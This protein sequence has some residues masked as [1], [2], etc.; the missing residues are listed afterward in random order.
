MTMTDQLEAIDDATA[1]RHKIDD[2]LARFSKAHDEMNAEEAKRRERRDRLASRPAALLEQTRTALQR[3]VSSEPPVP[4]VSAADP[5][6]KASQ[7]R[8]QEKKERH[9]HRSI[10]IA[11]IT[12]A[13]VAALVFLGTGGVWG[14]QT[15]LDSQFIQVAALDENSSDINNAAAQGGDE[16]FLMVGSDSRADA[17][18]EE[19]IGS[20]GSVPGARS[21]TVMIA[22]IPA[23]RHNVVMTSFPRDLEIARPDCQSWD[24]N[25]KQYTDKTSPGAKYAKLNTAFAAGGPQCVT[26]VIQKITGLKIN[27]FVAIDFDGFK[28]MVDAVQG[29]TVHTD[30]PIIDSVLGSVVPQA[31]DVVLTGDQALNFVRARHVKGD[32]TSDY[33]RIKRQQE[34][35]GA[36]LKKVMSKEVM[37][38]VSKI[39][40]F[41][42]G[43]AKA[44]SGDNIDVNQLLTLAESMRGL[45]AGKISFLTVP[46][47]GTANTRG[48]EVLVTSKADNLFQ[49]LINNGPLPDPNAPAAPNDPTSQ[50]TSKT[51][52]N[53]S[54][55]SGSSKSSSAKKSSSSS[56]S[57]P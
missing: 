56:N 51:T 13:V 42:T 46:T 1:Y 21:D 33:G 28:A 14:Y 29:V 20:A 17:S 43:F 39:S 11:R 30:T 18:D 53:T 26:K 44:T 57:A 23:D 54:T 10:M 52:S 6:E 38:S 3:V 27:H 45:D 16:N 9:N 12:A 5:N 36:L 22:H 7:T 24:P 8:L 41:V 32:P 15:F 49:A 37:L 25:T 55:S 19:G 2:T 34:F 50:T 48:N 4:A 31:G 40:G 35:I 47:T